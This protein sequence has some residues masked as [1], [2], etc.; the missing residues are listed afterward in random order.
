MA[1]VDWSPLFS[2][3]IERMDEDHRQLLAIINRF[4]DAHSTGQARAEI[5]GVLRDLIR[6]ADRH[7]QREEQLLEQYGFPDM[8]DHAR[9]HTQLTEQIFQLHEKYAAGDVQISDEVMEFV[10]NWLLNHI[11]NTDMRYAEYF[12]GRQIA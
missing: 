5:L 1:F 11:L 2:V 12:R 8:L 10:K 7:F 6:Y 3:G 9:I 4:H